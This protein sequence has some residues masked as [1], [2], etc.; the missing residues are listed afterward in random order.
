VLQPTISIRCDGRPLANRHRLAV[1][2]LPVCEDEDIVFI[3]LRKSHG[4]DQWS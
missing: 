3:E 4:G 1:L 2:M